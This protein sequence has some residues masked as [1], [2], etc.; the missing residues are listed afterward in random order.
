MRATPSASATR[1]QRW[2]SAL[3][4]WRLCSQWCHGG[5]VLD[6][7]LLHSNRAHGLHR[8]PAADWEPHKWHLIDLGSA[9]DAQVAT[10]FDVWE[11]T[12]YDVLGVLGFALPIGGDQHRLYC[13]EWC[14]LA[15]G[16]PHAQWMTPER[17]LLHALK[18][19]A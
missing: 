5:V 8:V 7:D 11:G 16:I 2:F 19:K 17:L 4:R 3:T 6:G 9:R 15:M 12:A 10:L 18:N 13:F 1:P 14:A